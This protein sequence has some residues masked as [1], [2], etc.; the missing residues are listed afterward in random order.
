MSFINKITNPFSITKLT[1]LG[2]RKLA[3]GKLNFTAFAIG[4]S[5]INYIREEIVDGNQNDLKLSKSSRILK[6]VDKQPN[7]KYFIS[8]TESTLIQPLNENNIE[9]VRGTVINKADTRG[10]FDENYETL[11]DNQYT[12][13]TGCT[14]NINLSGDT[15]LY[16]GSG[17]TYNVGD[18]VLLKVN[19]D[20]ISGTTI[21]N[22]SLP[23]PNLW[24]KI[25]DS[26]STYVE[27]DRLLPNMSGD[28]NESCY[29]IYPNGEINNI[30][31]LFST[32]NT[33]NSN[34]LSFDSCC[35]TSC[36]EI[37][38]WNMNNVWCEN[39]IGM[40]GTSLNNT[41]TT[42]NESFEKFGSYD[43]LGLKYP[44]LDYLCENDINTEIDECDIPGQSIIDPINKSISILHYTNNTIS[45]FYGE[46][47][48]IDSNT[49]KIVEVN[50][51]NIMYHRRNFGTSSGTTMGMKFISDGQ[52]KFIKDTDIEYYDLIED[53]D[54]INNNL[55]PKKVGKVFP[56]YKIVILDD[57]EIVAAISYKSNRN[58]TLPPLRANLVGSS[59][60]IL[61]PQET[62]WITYS[63]DTDNGDLLNE[64]LPC[65]Y[66]TKITNNTSSSKD[67]SFR[68]SEL[69]LLP[70]MRKVE[71]INYDGLGFSTKK[72]KVL[73]QITTNSD[74]PNP[75]NWLEHDYTN[76]DLTIN[77]NETIS[78]FALENPNEQSFIISNT[79][80]SSD[81]NFDLISKLSM[82]TNQNGFGLQFGDERFFYGN[83]DTY[84]GANIYK[85][86]FSLNITSDLYK[87][88]TNPTIENSDSNLK[89]SECGIYDSSGELVMISKFS[90]PINLTPGNNILL[91]L[92]MDF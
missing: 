11:L 92:S 5:E 15:K 59:N 90:R 44:Y 80:N 82:N 58:W 73:Y 46:F 37:P 22:T 13:Q 12:L 66:Y 77:S 76:L 91:E 62:M 65:Q 85:T 47:L 9:T 33:W 20:S 17:A 8:K 10:F 53:S 49:D 2:R 29:I 75:E 34:T 60:G 28:T 78:P 68:I 19:N 43:Y 74:R 45:N 81:N 64:T 21:T 67:V 23:R 16:I 51:P 6:S 4:D 63:L 24:Y 31:N 88:T 52:L 1:D 36:I 3:E 89:M 56:Q 38:I 27:L 39:L 55:E 86:I 35:D 83:L 32:T 50:I 84:I 72:F 40:T 30:F 7:L 41:T 48:F 26:G 87:H 79:N 18:F 70:Y 42:P 57:D 25:I 69:D 14:D 54:L 71:D 61:E